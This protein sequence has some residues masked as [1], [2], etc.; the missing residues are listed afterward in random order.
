MGVNREIP[1]YIPFGTTE[2]Y[3]NAS[4]WNYFTN[5]IETTMNVD[6][7][8]E[9]VFS[10]YPIPANGVLVVETCHG[11]SLP[12][13][14]YRITNLMGQTILSGNITAETQQIN[15]ETL[16]AGLYFI[17]VGNMT[18]KFVVK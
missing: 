4:G 3:Q 10:V 13:Q 18:Q 6:E 11:A 7:T 1:I 5:F 9:I 15:I 8:K 17:S 2:A 12:N 16:P 14:T